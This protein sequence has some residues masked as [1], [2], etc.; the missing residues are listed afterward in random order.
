MKTIHAAIDF[1]DS[2]PDVL[3]WA[4]R[5]AERFEARVEA[6]HVVHDLAAYTGIYLTD[7]PLDQLQTDLEVEAEEK[8]LWHVRE[9]LGERADV[10]TRILRGQPSAALLGHA[11][12]TGADLI[13][14]GCHGVDRPEHRV[15][16]STVLRIQRESPCPVLVVGQDEEP[17]R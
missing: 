12:A 8:L 13:V 11:K 9:A 17:H 2:S 14:I 1:S 7:R 3:R 10:A 5:L 16:G 4:G 15:T 6:V